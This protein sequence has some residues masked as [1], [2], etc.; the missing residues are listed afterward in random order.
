M[1][2]WHGGKGSKPRPIKD[3]KSYSDNWDNIFKNKVPVGFWEHY[4]EV[5]KTI[6]GVENGAQ[7]NWCEK[8]SDEG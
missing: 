3:H 1:T 6:L 5:E 2:K 7:C 4:C 8:T